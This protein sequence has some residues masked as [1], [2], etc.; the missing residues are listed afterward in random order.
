MDLVEPLNLLLLVMV[1]CFCSCSRVCPQATCVCSLKALHR[2]DTVQAMVDVACLMNRKIAMN[3][4]KAPER[5]FYFFSEKVCL[6][7]SES[8]FKLGNKS[9]WSIWR[10]DAA[11]SCEAYLNLM[12]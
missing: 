9:T 4:L 7:W 5:R 12:M 11:P 8:N 2:M 10:N 3:Y 1:S 6:L